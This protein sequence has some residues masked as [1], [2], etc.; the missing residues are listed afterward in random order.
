MRLIDFYS[1]VDIH[2]H[3]LP[4]AFCLVE[5]RVHQVRVTALRVVSMLV[6]WE[7]CKNSHQNFFSERL[8]RMYFYKLFVYSLLPVDRITQY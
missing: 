4:I 1:S 3:I 2:D 7:I 8:G 6:S 5:D